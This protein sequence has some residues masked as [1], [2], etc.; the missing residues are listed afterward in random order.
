MISSSNLKKY[1]KTIEQE[2][3][4]L[5]LTILLA[6]DDAPSVSTYEKEAEKEIT[7]KNKIMVSRIVNN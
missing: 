6:L 1:Q 3:K 4:D 7:W 2:N 5:L